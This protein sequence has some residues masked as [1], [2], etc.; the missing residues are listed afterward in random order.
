MAEVTLWIGPCLRRAP[1]CR[2]PAELSTS[3]VNY[4]KRMS[5]S[6][7]QHKCNDVSAIYKTDPEMLQSA[8]TLSLRPHTRT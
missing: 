2:A 5:F 6:K 7:D 4:R 1:I 3:G 8:S